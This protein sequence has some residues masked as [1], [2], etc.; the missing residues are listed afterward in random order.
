MA[1]ALRGMVTEYGL[2]WLEQMAG[3]RVMADAP[4]VLVF[5]C[6][7]PP[8]FARASE[9]PRWSVNRLNGLS[10]S[11]MQAAERDLVLDEREQLGF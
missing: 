7:P 1:V 5:E 8:R 11:C 4:G 3:Q 10:A 6:D 2:Q 9:P